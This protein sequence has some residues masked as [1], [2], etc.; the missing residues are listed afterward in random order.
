M[1]KLARKAVL[2]VALCGALLC[3]RAGDGVEL[4]MGAESLP[5]ALAFLPPPP[6]T[7]SAASDTLS[8]NSSRISPRGAC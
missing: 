8:A 7:A 1:E 2:A 4:Y 3:A 6:D 5:D